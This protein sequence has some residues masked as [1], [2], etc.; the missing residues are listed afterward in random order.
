MIVLIPMFVAKQFREK[1][2][3][4]VYLIKDQRNL[5]SAP[6]GESGVKQ[7]QF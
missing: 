5:H 2:P 7:L 1:V 4:A 6:L 3:S